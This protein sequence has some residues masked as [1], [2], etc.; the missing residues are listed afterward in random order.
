M[1]KFLPDPQIQ[2]LKAM[3]AGDIAFGQ[4]SPTPITVGVQHTATPQPV[5][6]QSITPPPAVPSTVALS[7][8]PSESPTVGVAFAQ[9]LSQDAAQSVSVTA[10]ESTEALSGTPSE[11]P[12]VG[13]AFGTS[14]V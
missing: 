3:R 13:V 8:T 4:G 10:V 5:V 14:V 6:N 9:T 1:S 11:S 12:V 2:S 7:G